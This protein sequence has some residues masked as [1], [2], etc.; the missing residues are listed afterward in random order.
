MFRKILLAT[1]P[2]DESKGASNLSFALARPSRSKLFIFYAYGITEEG[3]SSIRYLLPS[4]K[5]DEVKKDLKK[6]YK[7]ELSKINNYQVEVVPGVP[8][9]EIL[10]FAR[11]ENADLIVMGPHKI[12]K[13]QPRL[14]GLTGSTLQ[15]VSLRARCPVMIVPSDMPKI[16]PSGDIELSTEDRKKYKILVVDDELSLRDSLKEWLEEEGFTTG[17]AESGQQALDMLAK[18]DYHLMLTDIK[19]PGMDGVELLD[20]A[21]KE[22]PDLGVVMMTAYATIDTAVD[23][24]KIGAHDYLIKPFD[25]ELLIP[26]I[27][28]L[29]QDFEVTK[30]RLKMAFAS[31]VLATDF[32]EPAYCAFD[33]AMKIAQYYDAKLHIFHAIPISDDKEL[34]PQ[35]VIE[36]NIEET[37]D[38]MKKKYGADLKN[39][40]EYS[41]ESWEGT[42]HVEILKYARWKHADLIIMAHH[43]KGKDPEKAVLGSNVIKVASGSKCPILSINR[44]FIPS[45]GT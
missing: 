39:V 27:L 7:N 28:K 45:C 9:D 23:A 14:W 3:W 4:G 25:P 40:V 33:F 17:M 12:D 5:V 11:K 26:K 19:M 8:H 42:P 10:R 32:S 20:R 38:R 18:E 15:K 29:H 34:P 2:I 6:H 24:M 41:L 44:D 37:I 35:S 22:H 1:T 16:Y 31:I 13:N 43:S 36:K 21:K 30:G